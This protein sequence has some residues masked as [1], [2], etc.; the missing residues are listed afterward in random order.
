METHWHLEE[1]IRD[2][3]IQSFQV[4]RSWGLLN[5]RDHR[6]RNFGARVKRFAK[7]ADEM[8]SLEVV[9]KLATHASPAGMHGASAQ[10][11][12]AQGEA[13][14][15]LT[16]DAA[17]TSEAL[18]DAARKR[19]V[20]EIAVPRKIHRVDSL[21]LLGTGKFDYVSLKYLAEAL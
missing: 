21:P 17:L 13:L 8:V 20:P 14:V 1:I 4:T 9:E 12:G 3:S 11:N 15:L 16:T 10:A 6:L 7:V 18:A 5:L 19:G 2:S